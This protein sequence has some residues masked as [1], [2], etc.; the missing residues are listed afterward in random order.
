M[1]RFVFA[2]LF[3]FVAAL[4]GGD[5]N[6]PQI[7]VARTHW[8]GGQIDVYRFEDSGNICYVASGNNISYGGYVGITCVRAGK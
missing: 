1:K 2:V 5:D 3:L 6:F 8:H 4:N 7:R